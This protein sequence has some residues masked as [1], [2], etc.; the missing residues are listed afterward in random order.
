MNDSLAVLTNN[1]E[2]SSLWVPALRMLLGTIVLVAL[3]LSTRR[4]LP[5]LI[6]GQLSRLRATPVATVLGRQF[7]GPKK[8]LV[9]VEVDGRRLLLAE[10]SERINLITE[11]EGEPP[12]D[13]VLKSR[14]DA[15]E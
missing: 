8:A 12:F 15:D 7:I 9:L 4:W 13:Q 6:P 14:A 5:K 3:F 11:L 1:A 10:T 2:P